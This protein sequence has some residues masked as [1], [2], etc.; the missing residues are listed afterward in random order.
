MIYLLISNIVTIIAVIIAYNLGLRNKQ[1]LENKEEI[2]VIPNPI[3]SYKKLKREKQMK[4]EIDKLNTIMGNID[5]Y[6]GTPNG[7]MEVSK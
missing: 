2:K 6:D 1:I 3:Q 5:T 7:Q 4:D